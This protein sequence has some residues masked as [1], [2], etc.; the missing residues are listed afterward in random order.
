MNPNF[1]KAMIHWHPGKSGPEI[2]SNFFD[3]SGKSKAGNQKKGLKKSFFRFW[4][5]GKASCQ[6]CIS[7]KNWI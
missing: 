7:N 1:F 3:F 4:C 5:C 6:T 2:G